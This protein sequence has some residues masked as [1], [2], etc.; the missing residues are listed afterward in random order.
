M[1]QIFATIEDG[2]ATMLSVYAGLKVK[3]GEAPKLTS[4]AGT[5][6]TRA[7]KHLFAEGISGQGQIRV[8]ITHTGWLLK[9]RHIVHHK[10]YAL[11][12]STGCLLLFSSKQD[13]DLAMSYKAEQSYKPPFRMAVLPPRCPEH[14]LI[15]LGSSPPE[16]TRTLYGVGIS[17]E[18]TTGRHG[19][20]ARHC[21]VY[22]ESA[23][24]DR[25]LREL[26]LAVRAVLLEGGG[27]ARAQ[28]PL[29]SQV[30]HYSAC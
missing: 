18:G 11:L 17:L 22:S 14:E 21:H 7:G 8:L 9:R 13:A 29:D 12:L 2:E 19:Q 16:I 1:P 4:A 15:V 10:Y 3:Y 30:R 25:A 24:D 6:L 26:Q 28:Q 5:H 27:G 23:T 20:G